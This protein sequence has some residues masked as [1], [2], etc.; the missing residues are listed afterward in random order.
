MSAPDPQLDA[1]TAIAT[2][3]AGAIYA[4]HL[5]N[6]AHQ[7]RGQTAPQDF[8]FKNLVLMAPAC[9]FRLFG[10]VL[11]MQELIVLALLMTIWTVN[12]FDTPWLLRPVRKP[13]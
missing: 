1:A 5:M 8:A 3:S 2:D 13:L 11:G 4:C 7:A 10:G 6:Y 12:D 9:D